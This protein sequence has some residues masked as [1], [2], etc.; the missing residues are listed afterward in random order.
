MH[1]Q[2]SFAKRRAFTLI[3]LL[4]VIAII[5]VLVGLLLPAVQTAREAARRS[6][7]INNVKQLALAMHNYHD[8]NQQFPANQQQIGVS[9]WHSLSATYWILPFMEEEPLFSSVTIPA[10]ALPQGQSAAGAGDGAAWSNARNNAMDTRIDGMICSSAL[11]GRTRSQEPRGW[12]GPGSNYGWCYGSRV[13]ANWDGSSN[14]IIAQRSQRA[15]S[16]VLD[17]L[18]KTI[19]VGEFLSGSVDTAQTAGPGTYPRDIFY[20]GNGVFDAVADKSF[21]TKAELDAIGSAAKNSPT[22]VLSNNGTLPLWYSASQSAFNTA[23][24]PNW[25]WPSAGGNCC[26]GGSHDWGPGVIPPRSEH[27]GGVCIG[28]GDGAARF[29]SDSVAILTFQQLGAVADGA[30]VNG[31]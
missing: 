15:I 23:A 21:A 19:L 31:Y 3:E 6:S 10:N 11:P 24:P 1:N 16:E 25:T 30:A 8:A 7:C 29:I 17:G 28:M 14:G 2:P 9:V 18:S 13:Y 26:P 12:G 20:A 5:G 22:G 4:V 27:P